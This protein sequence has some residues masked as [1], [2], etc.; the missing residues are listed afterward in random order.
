AKGGGHVGLVGAIPALLSNHQAPPKGFTCAVGLRIAEGE[1]DDEVRVR[2]RQ[3][4][5]SGFGGVNE[6]IRGNN[7]L[8]SAPGHRQ[9]EA[10]SNRG[11]YRD[12]T[13]ACDFC[14][15]PLDRPFGLAGSYI[16]TEKQALDAA[17]QCVA[18]SAE[19]RPL[20]GFAVANSRI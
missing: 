20:A 14:A 5:A 16:H 4:V 6:A 7:R 8:L 3:R 13:T 17:S 10:Q 9:C 11:E 12:V 18:S 2:Q 15:V 19:Q 1:A